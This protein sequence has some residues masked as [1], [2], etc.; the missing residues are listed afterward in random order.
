MPELYLLFESAAGYGLLH[1]KSYDEISQN[2]EAV[3]EASAKISSFTDMVKLKA[4]VP[5]EDAE[6][7]L[8]NMNAIVAGEIPEKLQFFIS[9]SLPKKK[10]TVTALG[11][12]EKSL[13][14]KLQE[15]GLNVVHNKT[16]EELSRGCRL[17]FAKLIDDLTDTDMDRARV[18]LGHSYSRNKMVFDPNR[19]DKPIIQTIALIDKLDKNI[20]TFAMRI[21][22]WYSWHFPE[23]AKIVPDNICYAELVRYIG[24]TSNWD[25]TEKMAG[26]EEIVKSENIGNEINQAMKTSMGQE[27]VEADMTNVDRFAGIVIALASQRKTLTEYLCRKLDVVA[28]NLK[29]LIG[30]TVAARLISHAGSLVNLAKYPAST[31]QILGAEKAL[32]RAL[33]TKGK[34]PKYGLLFHSSFIGRSPA[35]DKGR[36]SRCLSNKCSLA[37]RI[38]NFRDENE[39]VS[40]IFGDRLRGQVEERLTFLAGGEAPRK[41]ID[42]MREAAIALADAN[43]RPKK[44]RKKEKKIVEE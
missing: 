4:F 23:L 40:G 21:K 38:D 6:E 27:I 37:A 7:A 2:S 15:T 26:L 13:A 43:P 9:Q 30:E 25:E 1:V 44:K 41:N 14:G 32:F 39:T 5:F 3:Q 34:T 11:V 28:P 12:S 17:H 24:L 19:Q 42:V 22:E 29:N 8:I 31:V 18:G 33:K 10:K 35:K 36:I 16:V 20:N